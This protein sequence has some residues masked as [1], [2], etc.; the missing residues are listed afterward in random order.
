MEPGLEFT[1]KVTKKP[2][3]DVIK[4]SLDVP[5]EDYLRNARGKEE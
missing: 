5:K 2:V 4:D 1:T 3:E